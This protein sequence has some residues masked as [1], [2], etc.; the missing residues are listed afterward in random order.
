MTVEVMTS[1]IIKTMLRWETSS[2]TRYG[3]SLKRLILPHPPL[4][5]LYKNTQPLRPL[6]RR[7]VKPNEYYPL[8][9][10][11]VMPLTIHFWQ[12]RYNARMGIMARMKKAKASFSSVVLP[13]KY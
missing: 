12:V 8:T 6:A 9:A 2:F 7:L 4:S 1:T 13:L 11:A 5:R 3:R 10:P